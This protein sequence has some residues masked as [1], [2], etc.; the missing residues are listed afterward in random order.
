MYL[1]FFMWQEKK[2]LNYE[3]KQ[4]TLWQGQEL[5]VCVFMS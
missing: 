3:V 5:S 2:F 4:K 1:I